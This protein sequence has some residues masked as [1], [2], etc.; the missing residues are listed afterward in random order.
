MNELIKVDSQT[1]NG[2]VVQAVS[3]RE[4]H[5]FLEVTERFQGWFDRQLQYGFVL[6]SD[7][8]GVKK[9]ASV[10]NGANIE[11][12]DY[13]ISLNMA[14]EIAMIQRSDKGKQ[15]RL[16]FIDCEKKLNQQVPKLP[17]TYLEA[18]KELVVKEETIIEQQK[19]IDHQKPRVEYAEAMMQSDTTISIQEASKVLNIKGVGQNKLFDLLR[20]LKVLQANNLPYQRYCDLQWFRVVETKYIQ[21]NEIK[22][23]LKTT[24]TQRGLNGIRRALAKNF[25]LVGEHLKGEN[26]E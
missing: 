25:G 2:E 4:L 20:T 5:K 12:Q 21:N 1:I 6:E 22:V 17:T 19:L 11:I 23:R 3:A 24:V 13:I 14:K 26:N 18:L 15:A 9:F 16:Y 10:N 7:F 8:T